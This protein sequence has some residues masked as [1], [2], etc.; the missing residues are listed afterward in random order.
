MKTVPDQIRQWVPGRYSRARH[1]RLR[2]QRRARGAAGL[3]RG[4]PPS[5]VVL[6]ALK[7]LADDGALDVVGGARRGMRRLSASIPTSKIRSP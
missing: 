1:R 7:A 5:I 2:A 6:E 3:L 4:R